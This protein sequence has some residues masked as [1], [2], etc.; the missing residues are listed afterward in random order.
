MSARKRAA[1][2]Y[3][4]LRGRIEYLGRELPLTLG[5]ISDTHLH[6]KDVARLPQEILDLFAR[7][8]VDLIV[9]GGDIVDRSVLD[10]LEAVAPVIAVHG[11]NEPLQLWKELPE[12]IILTAENWTIGIAHGHGGPT[13]R[14]TVQ[15]AF[16]VP[17]DFVIYGHSH[18]P[19]IEEIGG[20]G[21][22]NPGSPTDRRWSAHFGIGIVQID[23]QGIRP[24][25][26]LFDT[27]AALVSIDPLPA[28]GASE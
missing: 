22:F 18:I 16:P 3:P 7:F 12:R 15:T 8:E 26:I 19:V 14:K 17:V 10:R 21:Y 9:H 5:V 4:P 11:N 6:A 20:V 25:L 13:A 1:R 27:P 2:V 23:E 24:E 28:P